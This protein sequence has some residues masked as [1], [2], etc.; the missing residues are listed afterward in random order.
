MIIKRGRTRNIR[1]NHGYSFVLLQIE[2]NKKCPE[3]DSCMS[4][5]GFRLT[6][7]NLWISFSR[8]LS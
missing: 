3:E 8:S 6:L 4:T 5:F 2:I 1:P 7:F